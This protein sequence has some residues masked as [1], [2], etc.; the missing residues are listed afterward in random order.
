MQLAKNGSS[1][2]MSVMDAIAKSDIFFVITAVAVVLLSA[3]ALV[4]L[5]YVIRILRNVS[6]ISDRTREE[7]SH[8]QEDIHAARSRMRQAGFFAAAAAF[9]SRLIQRTKRK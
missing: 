5:V 7:V 1:G 4:A 2:T 9:I 3:F 8:I 6:D